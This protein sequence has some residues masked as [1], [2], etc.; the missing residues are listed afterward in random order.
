MH[1]EEILNDAYWL[2]SMFYSIIRSSALHVY[3]MA[4]S[5]TP[6]DTHLHQTYSRKFPNWIIVMQGIPQH[7]S[8]LVAVLCGHSQ[9]VNVLTFL[10]I[11]SQLASG[12]Y[13]KTARLWDGASGVP[14]ATLEGHSPLFLPD[15]SWLASRSDDN[16]VRLWDGVL[17]VPIATLKVHSPLP[18]WSQIALRSDNNT[19]G[20]WDCASGVPIATL[21]GHSHSDISLSFSPDGSQLASGLGDNTVRLWDCASGVPIATLKG[22]SCSITSLSFLPNRSQL[23]LGSRQDSVIVGLCFRSTNFHSLTQMLLSLYHSHLTGPDLLWD[24]TR[25]WECGIVLQEYQLPLSRVTQC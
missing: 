23:A 11:G 14:I 2:L 3:H 4:L 5:F 20:L 21:E 10:P 24:H 18:K 15:G 19:V 12:L 17:G 6:P 16:T 13:D 9:S 1:I 25:Q 7:W 22:H 8:C